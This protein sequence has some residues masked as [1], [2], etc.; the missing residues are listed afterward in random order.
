MKSSSLPALTFSKPGAGSLVWP[1]SGAA[2]GSSTE[3]ISAVVQAVSAE[4]RAGAA[5]CL[6]YAV[7][8]DIRVISS[9]DRGGLADLGGGRLIGNMRQNLHRGAD[10]ATL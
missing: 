1:V 8:T 2:A 3:A 9:F 10:R 5:R 6:A 7:K 4:R